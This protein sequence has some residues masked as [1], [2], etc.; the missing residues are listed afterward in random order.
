MKHM[1]SMTAAVACTLALTAC[2]G[3]GGDSGSGS[4]SASGR[5]DEG[6][7]SYTDST[8]GQSPLT[9]NQ[10]QA[11]ILSDGSYWG[12]YGLTQNETC[13]ARGLLQGAAS[14]SGSS[15]SGTYTDFS[16]ASLFKGTYSGTVSA[17]NTLNLTFNDPS[18]T[19]PLSNPAAFNGIMNYDSAYNQ[20]ASLSAIA[21]HYLGGTCGLNPGGTVTTAGDIVTVVGEMPG[22]PP[23][24]IG[25][26]YPTQYQDILIISGSN[27]TLLSPDGQST[28]MTGTLAP[29]GTVNVF[30]V[31]LTTAA[32]WDK[33]Q[34]GTTNASIPAGTVYKGI[35]FQ[36][37]SGDSN[38]IEIV[39]TAG[40]TAYFYKG[41][42]SN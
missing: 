13:N 25:G 19:T 30:D 8:A 21:G 23:T 18:N 26:Q 4:G 39:A 6:I 37:S 36:A 20:P 33:A 16:D 28:I 14:V 38:Y 9:A 41:L 10:M 17:Q 42:K 34:Y 31:S 35:L 27:L 12:I 11:V 1:M 15:V 7:W 5:A 2:G 3:G 24:D 29:H 32:A 22:Q 40:N